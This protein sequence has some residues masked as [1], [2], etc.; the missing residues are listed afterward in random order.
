MNEFGIEEFKA[1]QAG[2]LSGGNKRKLC[3]AMALVG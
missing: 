2:K 1:V 3:A